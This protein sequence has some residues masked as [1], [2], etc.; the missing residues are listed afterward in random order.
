VIVISA[1]VPKV[2]GKKSASIPNILLLRIL[3]YIKKAIRKIRKSL[4]GFGARAGFWWAGI[5]LRKYLIVYF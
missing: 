1:R 5:Q 3:I 2:R 4:T